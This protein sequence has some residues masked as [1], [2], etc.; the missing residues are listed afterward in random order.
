MFEEAVIQIGVR[1]GP[2]SRWWG[3]LIVVVMKL[4]FL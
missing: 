4:L 3:W 1:G 2:T